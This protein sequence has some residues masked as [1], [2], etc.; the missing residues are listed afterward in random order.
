L[1]SLQIVLSN[2]RPTALHE[3]SCTGPAASSWIASHSWSQEVAN[4]G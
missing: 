1:D 2:R 4:S 3:P